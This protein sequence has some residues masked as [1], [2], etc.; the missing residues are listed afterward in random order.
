[1]PRSPE[2]RRVS[3]QQLHTQCV[4]R[5]DALVR[6]ERIPLS[7]PEKQQ[8]IREVMDEVFGYGPLDEFLRDPFVSDIL[9]NGPKKIYIERRGR[10][11]P[12]EGSGELKFGA[13][14]IVRD[15]QAAVFFKDGKGTDILGPGRPSRVGRSPV[16]G[17]DQDLNRLAAPVRQR[18]S[19]G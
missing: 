9:V 1:M 19:P 4:E 10:L 5:I 12:E 18:H 6:E 16:F 8:L 11:R 2:A 17:E 15:S 3:L 14:C 7:G 13:Q